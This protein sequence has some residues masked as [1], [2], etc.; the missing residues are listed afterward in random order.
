MSDLILHHYPLSNYS[1]KVRL[2]LGLKR[3]AYHEVITPIA[4]PKPDLLPLT[5]GYRRAPVMQI[6]ANIYCDTHLIL[7]KLEKLHPAPTLFPNG[8]EGEAN[9]L[10]WWAER[11]TFMPALGFVANVNDGLFQP[12]FVAE[13]KK[14]GFILGKE[15]V[16]PHYARYVQQLV[17]HLGWLAAMLRDGRPYLL[18]EQVSAADLAA[19]PTVWFLVRNGGAEAERLL[20]IRDLHPWCERVAALGHG[21]PTEMP[22][23]TA[24]DI[25]RDAVPQRPDLP[26]N[27]DP[28]EIRDGTWVTVAPDDTGRDPVEGMLV[29]ASDQEVVISRSDE[30]VGEVFVHFPRAG[31]DIGAI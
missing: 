7:R 31:Y 24:L 18:G 13:R 3:L 30:R 15:D 1:E 16:E 6:G 5:G 2:A 9:A 10:A 17:A 25:A 23:V 29:A 8:C 26:A 22:A 11:Y 12:D 4:M 21:R 27:G 19:Y 14:F 28:S 20:P